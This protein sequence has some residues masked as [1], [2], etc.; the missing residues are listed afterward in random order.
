MLVQE[1]LLTVTLTKKKKDSWLPKTF[2]HKGDISAKFCSYNA[3]ALFLNLLL[4]FWKHIL[5]YSFYSF[6][7]YSCTFYNS[8]WNVKSIVTWVCGLS[9]NLIQKDSV[10]VQGCMQ[11]SPITMEVPA[12]TLSVSG[13]VVTSKSCKRNYWLTA[14]WQR[15]FFVP[16]AFLSSQ[17]RGKQNKTKKKNSN[18]IKTISLRV[19]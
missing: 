2:Y 14:T 7:D 3:A 13:I 5:C 4:L 1:L 6:N 12:E 11:R 19:D 10:Q 9:L 18:P 16:D 17:G 8:I 15:H